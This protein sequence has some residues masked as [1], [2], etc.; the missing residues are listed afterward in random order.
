MAFFKIAFF[1]RADLVSVAVISADAEEFAIDYQDFS[2]NFSSKTVGLTAED[3]INYLKLNLAQNRISDTPW[4]SI[5]FVPLS[6]PSFTF[7]GNV[8]EE[9]E[10]M[11][12]R[13]LQFHCQFKPKLKMPGMDVVPE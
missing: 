4:T 12:V 10:E 7:K 5:Q 6:T 11:A 1:R 8:S 9:E 13:S 2:A 3:V